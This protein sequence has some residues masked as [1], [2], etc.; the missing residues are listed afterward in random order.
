MKSDDPDY[1]QYERN[2]T[3]SF[4]LASMMFEP[5]THMVVLRRVPGRPPVILGGGSPRVVLS[6]YGSLEVVRSSITPEGI[7]CIVV[8]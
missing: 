3:L 5:W 2:C 6:R 7:L 8:K 4:A 1:L